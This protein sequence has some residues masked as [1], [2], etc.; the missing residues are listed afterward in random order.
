M[1]IQKINNSQSFTGRYRMLITKDEYEKFEES[2]VPMLEQ[3]FGTNFDYMYGK[4]PV[5]KYYNQIYD[6][7]ISSSEDKKQA[8]IRLKSLGMRKPSS[9]YETLWVTTGKTDTIGLNAVKLISETEFMYNS[10][11]SRFG[12]LL[13]KAKDSLTDYAIKSIKSCIDMQNKYFASYI[14]NRPYT[15]VSNFGELISK[16]LDLEK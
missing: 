8:E 12:I 9:K 16:S 1:N 13:G 5:S 4:S 3:K 10:G 2:V 14:K 15:K 11:F 7:F 6:Y